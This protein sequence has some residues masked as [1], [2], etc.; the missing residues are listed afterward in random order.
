MRRRPGWVAAVGVLVGLVTWPAAARAGVWLTLAAGLPGAATPTSADEFQ[1]DTMH[2]PQWVAVGQL[3]GTGVVEAGTGGGTTFFGGAGVPV[4]LSTADGSAYV[5]GGG[6]APDAAKARG[7]GGGGAGPRSSA[8]PDT[9][10]TV[11]SA[12]AL[13]G[14]TAADPDA[15][16]NQ[17]LTATVTDSTGAALGTATVTVPADGWWVIGLGPTTGQ[18]PVP[19]DPGPTDP[20]PTDP[21]PTDP[22]TGGG[23]VTTPEPGTLGLVAAGGLGVGAWRHL[24]RRAGRS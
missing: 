19:T 24:R 23:N 6:A 22:G 15:A 14:V 20:G 12:A 10:G 8:A 9:S 5:A 3:T 7:P 18:P 1:F 17:T 13:L 21:G 4:V 11:P 16:G 2:G